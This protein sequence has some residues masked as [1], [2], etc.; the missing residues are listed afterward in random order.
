MSEEFLV[1]RQEAA[2][3][4]GVSTRTIDRYISQEKFSVVR[5][6]GK[7]LLDKRE[8]KNLKSKKNPVVAQVIKSS[9]PKQKTEKFKFSETKNSEKEG[10]KNKNKNKNKNEKSDNN[11]LTEFEADKLI[12][13][14]SEKY[15][16]LYESSKSDIEN[17]DKLLRNMHYQLGVLET[18][19][20]NAIPLLEA[21]TDKRE[22]ED[23]TD[24]LSDENGRLKLSLKSA[25]NG[26]I[27]FFILSLFFLFFLLIVFVLQD[28]NFFLKI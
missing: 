7:V 6:G 23:F 15:K 8:L 17:R 16:I 3:V 28:G 20:K 19:S 12:T 14:D 25:K 27:F 24:K 1:T 2:N 9:V 5:E 22:W 4:L 11:I 10:N 13:E 18:E 21:E 26:R